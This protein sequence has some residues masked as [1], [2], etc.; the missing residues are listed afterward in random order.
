MLELAQIAI[1]QDN[2]PRAEQIYAQCYARWPKDPGVPELLLR[3]GIL[4]RNWACPNLA[5]RNS[6]R[7]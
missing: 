6:T 3:E 1:E 5:K 4:Y 2:L 7:S